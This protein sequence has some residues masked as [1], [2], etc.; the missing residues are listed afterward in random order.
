[1]DTGALF[2][3]LALLLLVGLYL[4]APFLERRARRA[5]TRRVRADERELSSL[6]AER[7][8]VLHA[9][10][11]LDFDHALG[12]IP[13]AEYPAQREALLRRGAEVLRRLDGL[14]G[15]DQREAAESRIERVVAARRADAAV[16]TVNAALSDDEIESLL[17]ARRRARRVKSAGFC[18]RCG[19]P[20]LLPDRFCPH[21]GKSIQ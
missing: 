12:K 20:V 19:A 11:E 17:A 9:L 5:E 13:T 7:D 4:Y 1:M 6:L 15:P 10:Q 8:R 14:L 2:L 3:L 16:A 21:C 18:P